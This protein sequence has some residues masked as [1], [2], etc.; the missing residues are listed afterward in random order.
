MLPSDEIGAM[1]GTSRPKIT[2]R[3]AFNVIKK[4]LGAVVRAMTL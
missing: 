1:V 4:L 3:N 2:M